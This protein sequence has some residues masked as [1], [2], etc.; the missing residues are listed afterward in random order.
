MTVICLIW[1]TGNTETLGATVIPP[2][3]SASSN[4]GGD[5]N[6]I[7][8]AIL[9]PRVVE[10]S[11]FVVGVVY[12]GMV[13]RTFWVWSS[14]GAIP[15][16]AGEAKT[17]DAHRLRE[18]NIAS[19][20]PARSVP[21]VLVPEEGESN[22]SLG[23]TDQ[24][25]ITDEKHYGRSPENKDTAP[26]EVAPSK[27]ETPWEKEREGLLGNASSKGNLP[28]AAEKTAHVGALGVST[29]D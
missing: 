1:T 11:F 26:I 19:P 16:R 20:L 22:Q 6:P 10:T 9:G 15:L 27:D 18:D 2:P 25:T 29:N 3:D 12:F 28:V 23:L 14:I 8:G 17:P 24:H 13:V 7:S 21:V 4:P 5:L